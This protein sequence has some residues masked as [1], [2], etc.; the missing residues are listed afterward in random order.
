MFRVKGLGRLSFRVQDVE[1]VGCHAYE[2]Q[3]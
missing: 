1:G 3:G 2:L